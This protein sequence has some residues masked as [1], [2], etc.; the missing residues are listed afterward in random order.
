VPVDSNQL[1]FQI[2][3]QT[4]QRGVTTTRKQKGKRIASMNASIVNRL[5]Y[6]SIDILQT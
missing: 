4:D 6:V 3:I 2:T 1:S 5:K